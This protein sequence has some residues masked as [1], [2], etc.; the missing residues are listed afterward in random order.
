MATTVGWSGFEFTVL[1]YGA[2]WNAVGG[3]YIFAGLVT[4]LPG[5][6]QWKAYYVGSTEDFSTRI[7]SHEKWLAALQLGATHVH[8]R[9]EQ[10]PLQRTTLEQSLIQTY[11]PPLNVQHR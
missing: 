9:V 8:A 1:D 7:P 11:Q 3:L 5:M 6:T 10:G 4:V 2:D